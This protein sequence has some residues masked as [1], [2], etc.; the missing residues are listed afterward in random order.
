MVV[1]RLARV[2]RHKF[3]LY[4]IVA[5]DKRRSATSKFLA[6]LGTYNPH[7]KK[8]IL[9]KEEIEKYLNA[10]AQPSDRV[11][12]LL[13]AQ[14][15]KLPKWAKTHDRHKPPKKESKETDDAKK[16]EEVKNDNAQQPVAEKNTD[17]IGKDQKENLGTAKEEAD[18]SKQ[19]EIT[20]NT[21][22]AVENTVS[23]EVDKK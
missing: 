10:G 16:A 5:A 22:K 11:L 7:D 9:N 1:I 15:V 12:R 13:I 23:K 18:N 17:N 6:I 20:E 2:G 8:V 21:A 4:R 19:A 14:K 3:P